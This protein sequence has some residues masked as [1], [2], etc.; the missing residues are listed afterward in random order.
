M[1]RRLY[2]P[3]TMQLATI[4]SRSRLPLLRAAPALL[5]LT[6]VCLSVT[7][8][9]AAD[10]AAAIVYGSFSTFQAAASARDTF[11]RE[12]LEPL[13]VRDTTR[14]GRVLY[15]VTGAQSRDVAS[16]RGRISDLKAAGRQGLWL[17]HEEASIAS[18]ITPGN[19]NTT[20]SVSGTS[21]GTSADTSAPASEPHISI[22]ERAMQTLAAIDSVTAAAERADAARQA[23]R[24]AAPPAHRAAPARRAREA[25]QSG[26]NTV[27][28]VRRSESAPESGSSEPRLRHFGVLPGHTPAGTV[29]EP[30]PAAR[31]GKLADSLT[32]QPARTGVDA[33]DQPIVLPRFDNVDIKVDG[34]L[35]EAIWGRVPSYSNLSVIDP[36]TLQKPVHDTQVHFLYTDKGLYVGVRAEQPADKL[37]ARLS[38]RDDSINRDGVSFTLDTSGEGLYGQWFG[39]NVGGSVLDGKVLP[40]AEFS[41]QWDGP[42]TGNAVATDYGY[43][44]EMF[45]PW[46]MMSMPDAGD[47]RRMGFYVSRKV[48]YLNERWGWPALP[49]TSPRF[50]SALQPIELAG[51][52]P[53][54]QVTFYPF[55][56]TT[57]DVLEAE[58][59]YRVGMDV[60]WRPSSNLQLAATLNPDFGTVESDDVVVNLTSFETFFPEK[61]LFFLEGSEIFETSPRSNVL[62]RQSSSSSSA[63]G[64]GTASDFNPTPTTLL[65]TRRIGGPA[66]D[67]ELPGTIEIKGVDLGKPTELLGAAKLTGQLGPVRF[68]MLGAFEDDPEF[69][70]RDDLG[71]LYQITQEGRDFGAVRFLYESV[72]ASRQSIG[73]MSTAMLHGA[74]DA[75]VHGLDGHFL[76]S[77]GQWKV[78][79]QLIASDAHGVQGYGGFG[80]VVY[81]PKRGHRHSLAVDYLDEDLNVNDFGFIRRNDD[82]T[83]RYGFTHTTSAVPM[84][85]N[86]RSSI[87]YNHGVNLDGRGTRLGLFA[88]STMTLHSLNSINLAF[89]YFPARWEDRNTRGNGDYRVVE[90]FGTEIAWGTNTGKVFSYSIAGSIQQEEL[91]DPTYQLK[92]G[93]T[94][95]PTD[96]F[97]LDFDLNY[98][99]RHNWLVYQG[100]RRVTAF[101]AD[102]YKPKI[103]LDVFLSAKQQLRF[104]LQW[105]GIKADETDLYEVPLGDGDLLR[106]MRDPADISVDD[107]TLSRLTA[108][109]RY[110]WEIA[111]LSDLFVVFTRGSNVPDRVDDSFDRLFRDALTDP[112][113]DLFVVK[114]RYRFGN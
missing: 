6:V 68:G 113:I 90:R 95:K 4:S 47:A 25:S 110:R 23:R 109:F 84:F 10:A 69:V 13:E 8:Q 44:A 62:S 16:L 2:L 9:A 21:A 37:V 65:N 7:R 15:R 99:R 93:F 32:L 59:D 35:D 80:D 17:M 92:T 76:S 72:T 54:Q 94:Y 53:R 87:S 64:R 42:W 70:G 1:I 105:A 19:L 58:P 24:G 67:P 38:S 22:R 57:Y 112:V 83:V 49:R 86:V 85:R 41:R 12:L 18:S 108:Q 77:T 71:N 82:M 30:K 96:R 52:N 97:S 39:I 114:L 40:E 89:M 104:T 75:F 46:S 29:A 33:T 45:L 48:A 63:G 103:A 34:K 81:V 11:E 73:W 28:S 100:D 50:M 91:G 66:V 98:R 26:G 3:K 61:R 111:P 106:W 5:C 88:R 102:E 79:G 60:F 101:N 36:D 51:V 31:T 107:F 78:D 43:S 14:E 74:G 27:A 20:R 55:A 56:A